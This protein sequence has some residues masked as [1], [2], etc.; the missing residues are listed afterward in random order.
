MRL[1][2]VSEEDLITVKLLKPI[3]NHRTKLLV[4]LHA[5]E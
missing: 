2:D 3:S 4:H 1:A 5:P